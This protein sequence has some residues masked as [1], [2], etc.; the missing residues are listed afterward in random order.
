M[1]ES[2]PIAGGE[3]K[4]TYE[5][6]EHI[7][8][9]GPVQDSSNP[10][11][12]GFESASSSSEKSSIFGAAMNTMNAIVGAGIIAIPYALKECGFAFGIMSLFFIGALSGY[13]LIL[14]YKSTEWTKKYNYQQ[15]VEATFGQPFVGILTLMQFSFPFF[16]MVSY[17]VIISDNMSSIVQAISITSPMTDRRILLVIMTLLIAL[18]LSYFKMIESLSKVSF[19]SVISVIFLVFTV[20]YKAAT[21][22]HQVTPTSYGIGEYVIQSWG[23]ILFAFVCHHNSFLIMNS[24]EER[25]ER[26]YHMVVWSSIISSTF[27]MCIF[28]VAGYV[29]FTDN[30]V[31]NLL[32]NF[33]PCDA[34]VNVARVAFIVG[35]ITTFPLECFV[36]RDIIQTTFFKS[37]EPSEIRHAIIT[38]LLVV[39]VTAISLI[40]DRLGLIME[41]TGIIAAIPYAFIFPP[42]L[43]LKLDPNASILHSGKVLAVLQLA[44][45]VVF[46]VLG[47][48]G[49]ILKLIEN[50]SETPDLAY[51]DQYC[52]INTTLTDLTNL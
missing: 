44:F 34:L 8:D 9:E 1:S 12:G 2:E 36:C 42:A 26:N 24:L 13:T 35:V 25:N 19:V 15:V 30:V 43:Y 27:L 45:G 10:E 37:Y 18:P 32:Q 5:T 17:Q 29:I 6:L 31:G 48:T 20:V 40:T 28:G 41:V 14:L 49:C 46:F 21:Q 7:P 39:S 38:I 33:C 22:T 51:C 52:H 11:Q 4:T 3:T 47:L 16:A 50:V 23:I